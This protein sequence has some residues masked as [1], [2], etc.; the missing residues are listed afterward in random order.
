MELRIAAL[1]SSITAPLLRAIGTYG[2]YIAL[3][4]HDPADAALA[5]YGVRPID[6][7]SAAYGADDGLDEDLPVLIDG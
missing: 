2:F 5:A 1:P 6:A 7:A 3:A 4:T